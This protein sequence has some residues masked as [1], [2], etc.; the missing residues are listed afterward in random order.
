MPDKEGTRIP[1]HTC[2]GIFASALCFAHMGWHSLQ[3]GPGAPRGEAGLLWSPLEL[4]YLALPPW[5]FGVT[6]TPGASPAADP[7][8]GQAGLCPTMCI[9]TQAQRQDR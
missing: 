6:P 1:L 5:G 2:S 4:P 8:P 9:S 7:I 3:P